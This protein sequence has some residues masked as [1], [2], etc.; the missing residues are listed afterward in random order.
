MSLAF[1]F[2]MDNFTFPKHQTFE[3]KIM[4]ST[5]VIFGLGMH[6]HTHT[7]TH[8][9]IDNAQEEAEM[10]FS[11]FPPPDLSREKRGMV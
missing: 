10:K 6:T 9:Y 5:C 4:Y 1:H 2:Q 11:C 8:T 3:L 7:H